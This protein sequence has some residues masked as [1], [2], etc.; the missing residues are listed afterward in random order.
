LHET[1]QESSIEEQILADPPTRFC[2]GCAQ[3]RL[4]T[5]FGRFSTCDLCRFTNTKAL[6]HR[7]ENNRPRYCPLSL[8]QIE[9]HLQEWVAIDGEQE[10]KLQR[11]S[12][13]LLGDL[14]RPL[15]VEDYLEGS[16]NNNTTL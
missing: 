11:R 8:Q 5:Q 16:P 7:R 1:Q 12:Y 2:S 10:L 14:R 9:D 15:T 4:N 3:Q 6:R 13:L